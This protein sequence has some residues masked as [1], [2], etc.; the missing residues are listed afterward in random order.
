MRV[1]SPIAG[2]LAAAA[3]VAG[4]GTAGESRALSAPFV[5]RSGPHLLLA[6][7]SYRFGGANIEWLGLARYGPP[8]PAGPHYPRHHESHNA[9]SSARETGAN[10]ARDHHT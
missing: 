8:D 6:G 10:D 5:T 3:L 2:V 7:R 4:Q 1:V 9:P